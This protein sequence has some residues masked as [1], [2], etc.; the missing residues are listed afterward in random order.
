[1]AISTDP[2]QRSSN[3]SPTDSTIHDSQITPRVPPR[4][5]QSL[6]DPAASLVGER[7]TGRLRP[8]SASVH[9]TSVPD[10][11]LPS[12]L[13]VMR[14]LSPAEFNTSMAHFYRGEIQSEK[15]AHRVE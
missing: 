4:P 13:D 12:S 3:Q 2:T 9:D 10:R 1:M 14:K 15:D 5:T 8:I 7:S 11:V 6:R